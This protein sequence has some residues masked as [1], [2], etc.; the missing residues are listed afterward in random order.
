V[1]K[2]INS[3]N[4]PQGHGRTWAGRIPRSGGCGPTWSGGHSPGRWRRP[5]PCSLWR[6][7]VSLRSWRDAKL[8]TYPRIDAVATCEDAGPDWHDP[9]VPLRRRRQLIAEL[10]RLSGKKVAFEEV[11]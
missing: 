3:H 7:V 6:T 11:A 8:T 10:E 5:R 1:S 4:A 2:H 9:I